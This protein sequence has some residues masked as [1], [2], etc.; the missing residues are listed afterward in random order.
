VCGRR[1]ADWEHPAQLLDD[2]LAISREPTETGPLQSY[3]MLSELDGRRSSENRLKPETVALLADK[4]PEFSDQ[5]VVFSE[6]P[7]LDD[8]SIV[9]FLQVVTNL[10]GIPKNT[11]RGNAFG[12]F[13]ASIGLWQI[14][15]RQGEI[16]GATLNDS[17]QKVIK[18]FGKIGSSTQL[19]DAGRAALKDL[20]VAAT[21]KADASQDKIINLLAGPY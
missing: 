2:L 11:L 10:N 18:P 15:A 8:A 16:P 3:L 12:T 13:Q 1:A 5:Y 9:A 6:F 4:F 19:F 21:G 20:M 7:E 14:L 17:W